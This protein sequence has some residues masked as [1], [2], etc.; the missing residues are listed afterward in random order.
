MTAAVERHL[1]GVLRGGHGLR[2]PLAAVVWGGAVYGAVMGCFGGL[3]GERFLQ[4]LYSAA[5]VPLL[6][7]ATTALALPSFFVLNTLTGLRADF[8]AAVR[9]VVGAQGAVAV[10]LAALAPYTLVWYSANAGYREATAFNGVVFAAASLAAQWELRRRYA[11]LIAANGKHRRM[12]RVW[13]GVYAFVGVQMGWI[14]R[15]FIGDPGRPPTFFRD[16]TWGNAYVIVAE[17]VWL[18]LTK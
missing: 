11:P 9:A 6:L 12:L 5:K 1:A 3:A 16:D 13:F 8:P 15:P 14:L 4:V 10:V 7:L 2:E 18:A 17:T